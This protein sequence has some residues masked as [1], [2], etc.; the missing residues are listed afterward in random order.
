MEPE[1]F[2]VKSIITVKTVALFLLCVAVIKAV[3]EVHTLH[4]EV[5]DE[6]ARI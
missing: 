3:S 1:G 4:S 5:R 6:A 2:A